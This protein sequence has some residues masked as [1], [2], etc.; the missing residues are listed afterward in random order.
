MDMQQQKRKNEMNKFPAF[1]AG[2]AT[3]IACTSR[4]TAER[5]YPAAEVI[6]KADGGW[7]CFDSARDYEGWKN[8]K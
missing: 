1:R 5:Y 3:F 2:N 7:M 8:Q 4:A 6:A